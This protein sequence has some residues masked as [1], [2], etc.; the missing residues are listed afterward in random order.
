VQDPSDAVAVHLKCDRHW[1]PEIGGLGQRGR[2]R[3]CWEHG[4]YWSPK[5]AELVHEVVVDLVEIQVEVQ[6][7][8]RQNVD[9]EVRT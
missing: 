2:L 7:V 6:V 4:Q 8:Q 9:G 1:S 5:S 3:R